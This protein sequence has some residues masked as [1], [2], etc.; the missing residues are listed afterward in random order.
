M[1]GVFLERSGPVLVFGGP[2]SNLQAA[3]ALLDAAVRRGIAPADMIC[4][5]D[6]VAYG[7]APQEVADLV[8]DSGMTVVMGNCEES[9]GQRASDCG[10]GFAE[11]STCAALSEQW[12]AHADARLDDVTRDWMAGLPRRVDLRIGGLTF[13]VIHGGI[14]LIARYL[15]ASQPAELDAE[16]RRAGVDGVIAGH[17]GLP[18]AHRSSAGLWLNAGVIGMP[19]NDATPRGWYAVLTPTGE[20]VTVEIAE[21]DY[22]HTTA[23]AD[24]REAGLPSGYADCLETGLWPSE[25]VLPPAERTARGK[26]IAATRFEWSPLGAVA[27]PA[28]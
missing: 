13:A 5:G 25:D 28:G 17:C 2:Y 10:C 20:G 3:Q 8:R 11:G 27:I 23:A 26:A 15:F 14:E 18:F 19:A 1:P 16:M 7:A 24:M 21:L 9:L 6:V 4:T 22:D 12:F